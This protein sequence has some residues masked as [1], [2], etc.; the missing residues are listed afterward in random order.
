[1]FAAYTPGQQWAARLAEADWG[2]A[3]III[4]LSLVAS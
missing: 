3:T 4:A 1:M 2:P